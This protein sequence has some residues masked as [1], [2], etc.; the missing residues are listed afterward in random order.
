MRIILNKIVLLNIAV[1]FGIGLYG[2]LTDEPYWR[3]AGHG[4]WLYNYLLW[5][6]LALNGPA[7][8]TAGQLFALPYRG[9]YF[10]EYALWVAL[11]WP[12]WKAYG[13]LAKWCARDWRREIALYLAIA[14]ITAIGCF[15][16][17]MD[18]RRYLHP[19]DTFLAFRIAATA[20][21]GVVISAY[22]LLRKKLCREAVAPMAT[23]QPGA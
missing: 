10:L 14:G 1:V 7:G 16:T 18:Q 4:P 15:M 13:I 5:S 17:Y 9:D 8:F 3:S 22:I 23:A 6:G 21:G 20:L 12:Q 19:S 2:F 11:L